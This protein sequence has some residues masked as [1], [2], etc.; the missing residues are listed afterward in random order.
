MSND[1]ERLPRPT[2]ATPQDYGANFTRVEVWEPH[3]RAIASHIKDR[4]EL[5]SPMI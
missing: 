2:F 4:L 3:V 5:A 1:F